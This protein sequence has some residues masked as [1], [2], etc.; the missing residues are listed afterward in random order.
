MSTSL[1]YHGFGITGY[2]YCSTAYREGNITFTISRKQ[3]NLCCP[4]GK[5]KELIQHGSLPR[6][7]H[8]LPI[9]KKA[10][11]IKTEIPRVEC[12][13]CK[14]IRQ[15]EV[16]FADPRFTYTKALIRYVFDLARHMTITDVSK[17][18]NLSWDIIKRD[19]PTQ[20][21]LKRT[22]VSEALNCCGL[23]EAFTDLDKF[24]ETKTLSMRVFFS[25]LFF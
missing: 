3:S 6:W 10:T 25:L 21:G 19:L 8:S 24:G 17:H 16:G 12:K 7:F 9:G 2:D 22:F 15:A 13:V 20:G 5:S 4:V 11:Y 18:L 1:L 14:T 23:K